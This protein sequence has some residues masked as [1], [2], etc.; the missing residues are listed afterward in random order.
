MS[1]NVTLSAKQRRGIISLLE[2]GTIQAAAESAGVTP[3]TI[4]RWMDD[5]DFRAALRAAE[6][7]LLVLVTAR[8]ND[9]AAAAVRTLS[10]MHKDEN[11]PGGVRVRAANYILNHLLKIRD[12]REIVERLE[13]LER[14]I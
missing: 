6:G 2:E 10:E 3:K 13:A 14:K 12:Q 11:Q 7:Q 5:P 4:Y 9:E 1:E 8:L